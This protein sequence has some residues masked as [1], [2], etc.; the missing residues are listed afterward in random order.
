M[1]SG[2]GT[3]IP[4]VDVRVECFDG[5]TH[6]VDSSDMAFKTAASTGVAEAVQQAGAVLLEPISLLRLRVPASTQGDVLG[7][8]SSR[9]GR[10]VGSDSEDGMQIIVAEVP[11]AEIARYAMDLRAITAGRG[12][13]TVEHHHYAPVP[14]HLSTKVLAELKG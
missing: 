6:S 10:V 12:T 5:K 7:D 14:D 4:I 2:A 11:T 1:A 8:L 13:Y 9:R 3:G